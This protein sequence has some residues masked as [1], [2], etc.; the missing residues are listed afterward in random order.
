MRTLILST[1]LALA[2]Y[3]VAA[4]QDLKAP[5]IS[6]DTL[7]WGPAPSVL[8]KGGQMAVLAGDPGKSGAVY[9]PREDACRL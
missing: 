8:P 7:K 2:A 9:G 3:G 6:P 5:G 1:A 4:A